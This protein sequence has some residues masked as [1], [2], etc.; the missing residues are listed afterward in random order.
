[1]NSYSPGIS[2]AKGIIA[3]AEEYVQPRD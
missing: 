1:M 3:M 2:L